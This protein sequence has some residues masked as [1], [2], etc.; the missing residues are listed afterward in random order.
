M[1]QRAA[2][3]GARREAGPAAACLRGIDLGR[4]VDGAGEA[5]GTAGV[6]GA[7]GVAGLGQV[8]G[9]SRWVGK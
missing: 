6:A 1:T 4:R 3:Q 8:G 5:A 2:R 9:A 7:A